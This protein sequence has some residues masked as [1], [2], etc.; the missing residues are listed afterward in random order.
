MSIGALLDIANMTLDHLDRYEGMD[1]V[2]HV[3]YHN[4]NQW[5]FLPG[6]KR[7]TYTVSTVPGEQSA[8]VERVAYQDQFTEDIKKSGADRLLVDEHGIFIKVVITGKIGWFDFSQLLVVLTSSF[9][10]MAGVRFVVDTTATHNWSPL[11]R[12]EEYYGMKFDNSKDF[13]P[14]RAKLEEEIEKMLS[15]PENNQT[16][17]DSMTG[18]EAIKYQANLQEYLEANPGKTEDDFIQDKRE[19]ACSLFIQKVMHNDAHAMEVL[20][21]LVWEHHHETEHHLDAHKIMDEIQAA[22]GKDQSDKRKKEVKD[23]RMKRVVSR[24]AEKKPVAEKKPSKEAVPSKQSEPSQQYQVVS[25]MD[26]SYGVSGSDIELLPRENS[27][28]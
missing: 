27:A 6:E 4:T 20:A 2:V 8:K 13:E 18:E 24:L 11:V 14:D 15:F 26:D 7:Y 16:F 22:E 23:A 12:K 17:L 3:V 25:P 19:E 10:L 1:L 9:T 5:S 21:C 28:A